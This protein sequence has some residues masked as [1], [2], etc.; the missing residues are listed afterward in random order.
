MMSKDLSKNYREVNIILD[1]IGNEYKNKVPK[2]MRK[3]FEE[4]EDKNY[5]PNITKQDFLDG[6][7]LEDTKVILSILNINYWSDP[8]KKYEYLETLR[9]LDEQY[10]EEHKLVL[11]EIFPDKD[12]FQNLAPIET[13]N[14]IT[15]NK[16]TG[17]VQSILDK[18]KNILKK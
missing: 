9:K 10:N 11:Q 1:I 3:L 14:K 5:L 17:I 4:A 8:E 16:K 15:D 18:I 2:K 7:Y 12:R 13:E 6:N